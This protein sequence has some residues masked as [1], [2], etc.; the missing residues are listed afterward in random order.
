MNIFA[1]DKDPTQAA[2]MQVDKHVVKM[3]LE[4]AQLLCTAHRILDGTQYTDKTKTGRN[5][6]RW[7][8]DDPIS[9]MRLHSATHINHPSA[10]W[11]RQTSG[12]YEWLY[13]HFQ[14]LC[15]EYSYRYGKYHKTM[16]M[17]WDEL[18]ILPRNIPQG[19]LQPFAVAMA[20]QYI[21]SEDPVTNYRNYYKQ[22][23]AHL[24]KWTKRSMPEW[25]A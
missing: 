15:L 2:V 23:K 1:L 16:G 14:A 20:P 9:D 25:M 24:H 22:G 12:N 17:L 3:I 5:V 10:V 8:L 21:V 4:T 6:K 19:N 18:S 7:R 13:H 11:C